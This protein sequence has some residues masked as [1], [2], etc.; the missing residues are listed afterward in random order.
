VCDVYDAVTS[1][2]AY[3]APWSPAEALS[4]MKI[5]CGTHLDPRIFNA[6]V[7]CIGIYPI[8]SLVRLASGRLA[9]VVEQSEKSLL[10]PTVKAFYSTKSGA[11][12]PHELICLARRGR[13]DSIV[14]HEEPA[15]WGFRDL[16]R[17]QRV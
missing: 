10:T 11:H 15:D 9:V 13:V 4:R 17:L 2:R 16:D 5:T 12:I 1:N 6:F 3:R 14:G 7:K 8:G